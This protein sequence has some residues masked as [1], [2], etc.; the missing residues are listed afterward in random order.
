[1]TPD[2]VRAMAGS[3][4][5]LSKCPDGQASVVRTGT[6]SVGDRSRT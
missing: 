6:V 4:P 3:K 5:S 1:M 2:R